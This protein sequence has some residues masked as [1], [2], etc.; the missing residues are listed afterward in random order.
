MEIIRAKVKEVGPQYWIH[1]ENGIFHTRMNYV[2]GMK[3]TQVKYN[4]NYAK[5]IS[6]YSIKN[7]MKLTDDYI[8]SSEITP[9]IDYAFSIN[10]ASASNLEIKFLNR[11][12][13]EIR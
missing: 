10:D 2:H 1:I 12:V 11:I 7:Y 13:C 3:N 9:R 5:T 4:R 8:E 6:D